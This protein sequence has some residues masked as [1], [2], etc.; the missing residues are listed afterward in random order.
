IDVMELADARQFRCDRQT[1][2]KSFK[3]NFELQRHYRYHTNNKQYFCVIPGCNKSFVESY[4]LTIH[5]RTHTGE[6]PHQCNQCKKKFSDPSTLA[7]H[8]KIHTDVRSHNCHV[9]RR[10]FTRK[11]GLL[12]HQRSYQGDSHLSELDDSETSELENSGFPSTP[13]H[14]GRTRM[15]QAV[16]PPH[17]LIQTGLPVHQTYAQPSSQQHNSLPIQQAYAQSHNLSHDHHFSGPILNQPQP[18]VTDLPPY[19]LNYVPGEISPGAA[20][21]TPIE[22]YEPSYQFGTYISHASDPSPYS[23]APRSS[24]VSQAPH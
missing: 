6:K 21:L 5:I 20:T 4:S 24:P 11:Y 8:R 14:S 19:T 23:S 7:K 10:S 22:T 9:C 17:S 3:R 2:G 16:E 13:Q 12:K 1:C 18:W 15:Q